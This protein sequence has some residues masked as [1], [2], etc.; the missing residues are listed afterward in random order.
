M[1]LQPLTCKNCGGAINRATYICEYCGTAY[2]NRS[3]IPY[4]IETQQKPCK[5]LQMQTTIPEELL[6]SDYLP[7]EY[8]VNQAMGNIRDQLA[9][10]LEDYLRVEMTYDHRTMRQIITAQVRVIEPDYRF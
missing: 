9:K 8:I 3:G 10:A 7:K 6:R 1:K 5:V 2:E 4:I